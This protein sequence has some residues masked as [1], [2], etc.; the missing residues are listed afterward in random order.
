MLYLKSKL[1]N[2]LPSEIKLTVYNSIFKLHIEY[3]IVAQ[4]NS[5]DQHI[6]T[7][8]SLQKRSVRYISNA[9]NHITHKQSVC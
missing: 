1:K 8:S 2:F 7:M 3:A 5:A 9:R 6:K 4:V